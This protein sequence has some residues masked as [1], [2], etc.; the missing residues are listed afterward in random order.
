MSQCPN[1][2]AELSGRYCSECGQARI[3]PGDLSARRFF[4]DLAEETAGLRV[5]FKTLSSLGAL[6]IP[7]RLTGEYLAGR[8]QPYLA[9]LQIYLV[10]AALFFLA[11]PMAGFTLGSMIA[12]D[13][14]GELASL[15]EARTAE[16]GLD[17]VIVNQR[18][19]VKVKTVYTIALGAGVILMALLLQLLFR[20]GLP[21]GAHLALALHYFSFA[22]LATAFV[23]IMHR[24]G[25]FEQAAAG[26][27]VCLIAAYLFVALRRIYAGSK[28][29][30]L[31]RWAAVFLLIIALNNLASVIAIRL[32]LAML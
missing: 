29:Y 30:I 4:K 31:L 22:Y 11:A 1:C 23:G 2:T 10:C 19:D 8:R 9:P 6:L 26:L 12:S 27:G 24:L 21:F 25:V 16:R 14:T 15:V 20:A 7:G 13:Q 17:P 28:A 3:A 5:K 32:T 18:F